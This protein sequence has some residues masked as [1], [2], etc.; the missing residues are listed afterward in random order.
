MFFHLCLKFP[1]LFFFFFIF[2][3]YYFVKAGL[4]RRPWERTTRYSYLWLYGDIFQDIFRLYGVLAG[5]LEP[6]IVLFD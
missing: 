5:N 3:N 2:L 1:V 6:A 4:L